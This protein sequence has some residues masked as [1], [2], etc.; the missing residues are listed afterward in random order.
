MSHLSACRISVFI[1]FSVLSFSLSLS[2]PPSLMLT[3]WLPGSH[4]SSSYLDLWTQ[5]EKTDRQALD[6]TKEQGMNKWMNQWKTAKT[7]NNPEPGALPLVFFFLTS[8][9]HS[10]FIQERN[11]SWGSPPLPFHYSL[12]PISSYLLF[13]FLVILLFFPSFPFQ[14]WHPG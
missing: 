5:K 1:I 11:Y 12:H 13:P 2:P 3:K 6:L 9:L 10:F 7:Y 14:F 8:L 4:A